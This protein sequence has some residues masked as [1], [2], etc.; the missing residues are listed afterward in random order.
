MLFK[1]V[2]IISN[3]LYQLSH[4]LPQRFRSLECAKLIDICAIFFQTQS[5]QPKLGSKLKFECVRLRDNRKTTDLSFIQLI[6]RSIWFD[7]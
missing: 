6:S 7:V 1:F 4:F 5:N 2:S 3:P